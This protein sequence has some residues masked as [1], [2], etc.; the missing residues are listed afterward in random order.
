[1]HFS[2]L[3]GRFRAQQAPTTTSKYSYKIEDLEGQSVLKVQFKDLGF[4]KGDTSDFVNVQTWFYANGKLEVRYGPSKIS[5]ATAKENEPVVALSI[6]DFNT[7]EVFERFNLEGDPDQ[8]RLVRYNQTGLLGYPS[9]GTVYRFLFGELNV[10]RVEPTLATQDLYL[11]TSE[12]F[13]F[14]LLGRKTELKINTATG[15]LDLSSL[16]SGVYLIRIVTL[17]GPTKVYKIVRR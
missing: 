8:P 12:A 11:P 15:Q 16:L 1:M 6:E 5:A 2:P 17:E 3:A 13:A 4:K 9:D 14:D 10:D 7:G